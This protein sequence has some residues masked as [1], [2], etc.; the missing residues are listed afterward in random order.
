LLLLITCMSYSAFGK[1]HTARE[2][3]FSPIFDEHLAGSQ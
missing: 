1:K 3:L 2:G